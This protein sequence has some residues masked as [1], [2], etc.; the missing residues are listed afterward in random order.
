MHEHTIEVQLVSELQS[1]AYDHHIRMVYADWCEERGR[2]ARA[3]VLRFDA[4]VIGWSPSV[5]AAIAQ[6]D[7]HWRDAVDPR[8]ARRDPL[9]LAAALGG[10]PERS[11]LGPLAPPAFGEPATTTAEALHGWPEDVLA[12]MAVV[13]AL[14]ALDAAADVTLPDSAAFARRLIE[15]ALA[16]RPLSDVE[17]QSILLDLAQLHAGAESYARARC[18]ALEA[19]GCA[20]HACARKI[21]EPH[22]RRFAE[23]AA[24]AI[25][26]ACHARVATAWTTGGLDKRHAEVQAL[27][28][29]ARRAA[30]RAREWR[31]RS[32]RAAKRKAD[33]ATASLHAQAAYQR[34]RDTC[35]PAPSRPSIAREVAAH[36]AAAVLRWLRAR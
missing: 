25:A 21:V 19:L 4:G 8:A 32:R 30:R 10:E 1:R 13:A 28:R 17:V 12:H 15:R 5:D 33:I 2:A 36:V 22:D 11:Q 16:M 18:A 7:A 35:P 31:D 6:V 27:A 20:A 34:A 3:T 26:A 24:R 14:H 29:H 9:W 23:S